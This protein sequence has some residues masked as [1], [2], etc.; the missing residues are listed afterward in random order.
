VIDICD[1]ILDKSEG[2]ADALLFKGGALGYRGLV[3]AIRES[4]LKSA[5]DGKKSLH[6]LMK[7]LELYPDNKDAL[8]GVGVYNYYADK[9]PEEKPILKPLTILFPKGDKG[10]GLLQLKEAAESSKYS[11]IEARNALS[12]IDLN[13][14]QNFTEAETISLSLYN[15]YEKI[16][17]KIFDSVWF[18]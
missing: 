13:Y 7:V 9:I 17:I 16:F 4:Y 6:L 11:K 5:E 3:R 1:N 14:E 10:K 18:E 15:D 2:D 8:F 12:R